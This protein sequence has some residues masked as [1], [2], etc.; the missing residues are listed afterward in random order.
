MF[1]GKIIWQEQALAMLRKHYFWP[2][3]S[4]DTQYIL[5]R[6]ATCQV[7]KSH[8]LPHGLYTPLPVPTL[9]WVDVS[10]DFVL[11]LPK[12]QRSKDSIFAMVNRFSKMA[13]SIACNKTDDATHIIELYSKEI[14]RLHG[15]PR[16]IISDHD[17]KF[18][19]HF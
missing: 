11:G 13:H 7:A 4:K 1:S 16:S 17:T 6:C 9:P 10:M 15:I 12:A 18:L 19:G 5:R 2:S 14:I 8:S 3:V